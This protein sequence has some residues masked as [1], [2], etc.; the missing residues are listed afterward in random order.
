M[1]NR[2]AKWICLHCDF[3]NNNNQLQNPKWVPEEKIKSCQGG[4]KTHMWKQCTLHR[5]YQWQELLSSSLQKTCL[6]LLKYST[7]SD[8][9]LEV[10]CEEIGNEDVEKYTFLLTIM[11]HLLHKRTQ[12]FKSTTMMLRCFTTMKLQTLFFLSLLFPAHLWP[13]PWFNLGNYHPWCTW[14]CIT[15]PHTSWTYYEL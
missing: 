2:N 4:W 14:H 8:V 12:S 13:L 1:R 10:M 7:P 11:G 9:L 6:L 5:P 3:R 15:T